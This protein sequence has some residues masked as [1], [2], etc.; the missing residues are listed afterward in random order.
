MPRTTI[1]SEDIT[2]D[3][4]TTDTIAVG[5]VNAQEIGANAVDTSEIAANAVTPV[6]MA[7]SAYLAN[8]NMIINGAMLI[9]Q[10]GTAAIDP[11][12]NGFAVD[13]WKAYTTTGSGHTFQQVSDSPDGF[14]HSIKITI[15][16]GA[17]PSASNMNV[18]YQSIEGY[19]VSHLD[20][21]TSA[22]LSIVASFWVKSS[23]T[24]NYGCSIHNSALDR[25]YV[26]QYTVS[27]ADTWEKKSVTFTGDTTGTWL[28]TTGVGM[29]IN[30]DFGSGT[31]FEVALD[32]WV[33]GNDKRVSGQAILVATSSAT[34]QFSGAQLEVGTTATPFERKTFDQEL[35]ACQ[36]Y[37]Q[38]L[39]G[40]V[41][42]SMVSMQ[43]CYSTIGTEGVLYYS[44]KRAAPTITQYSAG[45]TGWFIHYENT[46]VV[47]SAVPTFDTIDSK[48]CRITALVASGLTQGEAAYLRTGNAADSYIIVDAEL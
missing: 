29:H 37:C 17:S 8:R 2:D 34:I 3:Q 36:R 26:G 45:V 13:R 42:N 22:A 12:T 25:S 9:A 43:L 16:T 6:Q 11:T 15:G 41:T 10:R 31:D 24:G 21:G 44:K 23:I 20:F 1:R 28:K 19:N 32:T 4:I 47:V 40:E 33:P 39:H 7:D 5:A 48:T 27:V 46:S 14:E 18:I 30:F 35:I 38:K